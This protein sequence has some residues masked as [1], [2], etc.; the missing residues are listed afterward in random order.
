MRDGRRIAPMDTLDEARRRALQ[1]VA[2]L[3]QVNSRSTPYPV[4]LSPSLYARKAEL[5]KAEAELYT[6]VLFTSSSR[7][8]KPVRRGSVEPLGFSSTLTNHLDAGATR[9]SR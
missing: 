1:A 5:L 6:E 7:A 3:P 2:S 9:M 4:G 8:V